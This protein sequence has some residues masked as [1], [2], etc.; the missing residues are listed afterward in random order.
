MGSAR[1][2]A[3]ARAGG[4]GGGGGLS[5]RPAQQSQTR[6]YFLMRPVLLQRKRKGRG[7]ARA[8]AQYQIGCRPSAKRGLV[9]NGHAL[10]LMANGGL[11]LGLSLRTSGTVPE[12]LG[13]AR[14]T[15]PLELKERRSARCPRVAALVRL[16]PPKPPPRPAGGSHCLGYHLGPPEGPIARARQP[17]RAPH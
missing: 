9:V 6:I 11:G 14:F 12:G 3:A 16:R 15:K 17:F 4:R 13:T 10:C 7:R 8:Q 5:N 2:A 1:A